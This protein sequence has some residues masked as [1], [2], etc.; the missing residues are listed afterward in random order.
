MPQKSQNF[1]QAVCNRAGMTITA[2]AVT[3]CA[4]IPN[5]AC[6][7]LVRAL[8]ALGAQNLLTLAAAIL[9]KKKDFL[10]V[11][12]T[13]TVPLLRHFGGTNELKVNMKII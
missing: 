5:R 3:I 9:H 10:H 1:L 6:P 2:S 13:T 8:S 12:L 11:A 7:A 4:E